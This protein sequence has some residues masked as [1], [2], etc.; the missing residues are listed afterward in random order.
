M[1]LHDFSGWIPEILI[2][3]SGEKGEGRLLDVE[4]RWQCLQISVTSLKNDLWTLSQV[5]KPVGQGL[6]SCFVPRVL[7]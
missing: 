1:S 3:H 7:W 2:F 4:F 5:C 6:L